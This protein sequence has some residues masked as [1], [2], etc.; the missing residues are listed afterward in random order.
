MNA[1]GLSV[2]TIAKSVAI[3]YAVTGTDQDAHMPLVLAML[4]S[5][6]RAERERGKV[7]VRD[8]ARQGRTKIEAQH[9]AMAL[10]SFANG[11]EP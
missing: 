7:I 8:W 11:H 1:G 10:A 5:A 6:H 9:Q 3:A 4:T 2:V